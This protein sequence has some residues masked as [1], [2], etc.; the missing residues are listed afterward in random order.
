MQISST[1]TPK[2]WKFVE[3]SEVVYQSNLQGLEFN[4]EFLS[5]KP[6]GRIIVHGDNPIHSGYAWDGCTPKFDFLDITWGTPDGRL[7]RKTLKPITYYASLIHDVLYQYKDS[8]PVS[9]LDADKMFNIINR[10][11]KF[12]LAGLYAFAVSVVGPF[13]GKWKV[14]GSTE[15]LFVKH[16]N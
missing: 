13:L 12:K 14:K 6:D 16:I 3:T 1:K 8:I 9:R 11:A 10:D 2:V 5:I 7:D 15:G 4:N